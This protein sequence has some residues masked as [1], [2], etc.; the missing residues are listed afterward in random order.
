M[1]SA[2][3][4]NGADGP[5]DVGRTQSVTFAADGETSGNDSAAGGGEGVVSGVGHSVMEGEEESAGALLA[6][7]SS[8][9]AELSALQR[10]MDDT[11]AD[12]TLT[13][14][15]GARAWSGDGSGGSTG[16]AGAMDALQG[17]D[18]TSVSVSS[19]ATASLELHASSRADLTSGT[20][21]PCPQHAGSVERVQDEDEDGSVSPS[22]FNGTADHSG[23]GVVLQAFSAAART[24]SS[25][26]APAPDSNGS[27]PGV[28][29]KAFRA[30]ARKVART[31]SVVSSMSQFSRADSGASASRKNAA[32]EREAAKIEAATEERRKQQL[33][34]VLSMMS[35]LCVCLSA[36]CVC[37]SLL[38]S[39]STCAYVCVYTRM[40]VRVCVHVCI[41]VFSHIHCTCMH[42][43]M[44]ACTLQRAYALVRSHTH[45]HT[46]TRT[47]THTHTHTHWMNPHQVNA[48][49]AE[50]MTREAR[51]LKEWMSKFPVENGGQGSPYNDRE[52]LQKCIYLA[53]KSTKLDLAKMGLVD[54]LPVDAY[55]IMY[56]K[57]VLLNDNHL[58]N[59]SPLIGNARMG[60]IIQLNL[61]N[62]LLTSLPE[63]IGELHELVFL[64]LHKNHLRSAPA[65][66]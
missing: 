50:Q 37:L 17:T 41:P 54:P 56:V 12:L 42:A 52:K 22:A 14:S 48:Q 6:Q 3:A 63:E 66:R 57:Q 15:G 44:D 5:S 61:A 46:H 53:S 35:A 27:G 2:V 47:H 36:L 62:N 32:A 4:R 31:A 59:I 25:G 7:T 26:T 55:T 24:D 58:I 20:N 13:R 8:T 65:V 11:P 29:L 18:G 21:N 19:S 39:L 60:G 33:V 64:M 10:D 38:L 1:V 49:R 45:T 43:I 51:I 40:F 28:G 9:D 34:F 23:R 16:V 30:A